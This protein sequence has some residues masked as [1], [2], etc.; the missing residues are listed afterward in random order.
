MVEPLVAL[1]SGMIM[2]LTNLAFSSHLERRSL[3]GCWSKKAIWT[4]L[5]R[6]SRLVA[7]TA[8]P[9]LRLLVPLRLISATI[10][11]LRLEQFYSILFT[12]QHWSKCSKGGHR[13]C[14]V[15]DGN[16]RGIQRGQTNQ[17]LSNEISFS[18]T[19]QQHAVNSRAHEFAEENLSWLGTFCKCLKLR[20]EIHSSG[21]SVVQ[22]QLVKSSPSVRSTNTV[23]I[24]EGLKN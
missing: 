8:R 2:L 1:H 15:H 18:K 20:P 9:V 14:V 7:I 10:W 13:T 21:L 17:D 11:S 16:K 3:G 6:T 19:H 12:Q 23:M 4:V 22:E 5:M 24:K